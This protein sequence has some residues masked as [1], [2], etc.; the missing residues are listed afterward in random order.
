VLQLERGF[1]RRHRF[2]FVG[3]LHRSGTTL[4][5]QTLAAHR[6]AS[7]LSGTGVAEDE[8]QHLQDVFPAARAIGGPGRFGF[9]AGAHLTEA[10][11]LATRASRDRL[12]VA[13]LP[14]WDARRRVL[15]EKSPPNLLR[16]RLL[17]ALFPAA[18]FVLIVRHPVAVAEATCKWSDEGVGAL[19]RHWVHCHR[20]MLEDAAALR[21]VCLVRYEDLVARPQEVLPAVLAFIGLDGRA[22]S[23]P[24]RPEVN[25]RYFAAWKA[26]GPSAQTDGRKAGIEAAARAFGY[27]MREPGR[28]RAPSPAVAALFTPS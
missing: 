24:L 27:A 20:V 3:G 8:G 23:P 18:C 17:Q 5:A 19:L 12:L 28:Y 26:R 6:D 10:S 22:P 2:V 25:D 13:W 7:G 1:V 4:L 11:P 16:T 14:Y 15:V 21:R 9:S